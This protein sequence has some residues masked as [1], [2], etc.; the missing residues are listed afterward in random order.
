[1]VNHVVEPG[2]EIEKAMEIINKIATKAPVAIQRIIKIVNSYFD[3]ELPGYES[4][5]DSFGDLMIT[6]DTKEGVNAFLNK[7]KPK[8]TGK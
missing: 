1:L 4:E 5:L 2:K 6:D 8:F 3:Y 7:R